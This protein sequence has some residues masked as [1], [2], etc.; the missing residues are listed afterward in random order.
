MPIWEL[1]L[2]V[3]FPPSPEVLLLRQSTPTTFQLHYHPTNRRGI[4]VL[5]HYQNHSIRAAV[6]LCKFSNHQRATVLLATLVT[7]WIETQP[8]TPTVLLPI[9]LHPT[10]I[11][12]RGY[13]QVTRVLTQV[14]LPPHFLIDTSLLRR[15]KHTIP[16]TTLSRVE[17]L[18]NLKKA[19][20]VDPQRF[21]LLTS[22][23][24]T[25]F[26]ICDDVTTTGTTLKEAATVLK[27]QLTSTQELLC[28]A[29][30]G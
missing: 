20:A 10:R 15:I 1:L 16:Q 22:S 29:W 21:A 25:R 30:S 5:S 13:N 17:R 11:R 6:T 9:P 24:Y 27:R 19:F 23:G 8:T 28:I 3:L 18:Q 14:P 12:E 4:I 2:D 26:I 7:Q